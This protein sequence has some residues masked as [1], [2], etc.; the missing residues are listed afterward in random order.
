MTSCTRVS[1][2]R[3][4]LPPHFSKLKGQLAATHLADG[5]EPA[6]GDGYSREVDPVELVFR[7][8][9]QWDRDR[10]PGRNGRLVFAQG[11]YAAFF[12]RQLEP[13]S[14]RIWDEG[15]DTAA[16]RL[17]Q[18]QRLLDLL[19]TAGFAPRV[20][21]ARWLIQTAQ[22][23]LTR[24]LKPYFT[25]AD[26]ISQSFTERTAS[27]F[28]KAGVMLASGHLRSQLRHRFVGDRLGVQ[29]FPRAG[30][31]TYSSA[32]DFALLVRD[33]VP[34]LRAYIAA[35]AHDQTDEGWRW[36]T[37]SSRA[38]PPIPNAADPP[39]SSRPDDDD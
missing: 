33:L 39:G 9:H 1:S 12:L 2:R 13:L 14:L 19:N 20:R 21:D 5:F 11:L 29:R 8:H 18:V 37:P 36:R 27:R 17:Q 6:T 22:G 7:A 31:D 23:P 30:H 25:T 24:H 16:E 34:L 26:R 35:S 15:D 32:M 38:C 4:G 3:L 28:D 10:W